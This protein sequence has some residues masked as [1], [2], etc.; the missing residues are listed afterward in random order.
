MR[1]A[2]LKLLM[3]IEA[4]KRGPQ[5]AMPL[6]YADSMEETFWLPENLHIIGTMNTADRSLA[7]VDY[8]LRRRFAFVTL[9][10]ALH[11][12]EFRTWLTSKGAPAAFAD[13][14]A[15]R[16]GKLNTEISAERDLGPGFRIGHSYFCPGDVPPDWEAWYR[17]IIDAEIA[18][19]LEEYFDKN[20]R[21]KELTDAL[22]AG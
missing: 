7:M 3:L 14:I 18:P 2:L 21:V 4:D 6:T 9:E 8:A 1:V 5:F 11:R 13:R 20:T 22:L 17:D 15:E 10:P 12:T 19:L 16:V